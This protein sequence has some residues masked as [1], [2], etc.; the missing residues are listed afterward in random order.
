M[1]RYWDAEAK[2]LESVPI[3]QYRSKTV[4]VPVFD[5]AMEKGII[6]HAC[7]ACTTAF[8]AIEAAQKLGIPLK[9]E[10]SGHSDLLPFAESGYSILTF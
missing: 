5:K 10:L 3:P 1:R 4:S 9:G 6:D 8:D 7:K 2:K